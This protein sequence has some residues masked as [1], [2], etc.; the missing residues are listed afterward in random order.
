MRARL[1]FAWLLL[2][3]LSCTREV[4]SL[5]EEAIRFAVT[6][7]STEVTKTSYD[8]SNDPL[9]QRIDW[10]EGDRVRIMSDKAKA[11]IPPIEWA[12][13]KVG[14]ITTSGKRSIAEAVKVQDPLNWKSGAHKFYSL[15]PS[16]TTEGMD[17]KITIV[18]T[19]DDDFTMTCTIPQ[20]Q[21]L[22][23]TV[24]GDL[25]RSDPDMRHAYLWAFTSAASPSHDIIQLEYEPRFTAFEFVVTSS[26]I[27]SIHLTSFTLSTT[28]DSPLVGKFTIDIDGTTGNYVTTESSVSFTL[29]KILEKDKFL[30]ITVL[31][32]PKT[33]ENLKISFT[34]DEI[35]TRTLTI[36]RTD[37]T[38][39]SFA[40][41]KKHRFVNLDF[42]AVYAVGE[43]ITWKGQ[44][45]TLGV[46]ETLTWR[47]L[48]DI[49]ASG[50][51]MNESGDDNIGAGGEDMGAQTGE[52]PEADGQDMLPDDSGQTLTAIFADTPA[53]DFT[54]H[55]S[56]KLA[57]H[58]TIP[59]AAFSTYFVS[60]LTA[61]EGSVT[62][63]FQVS[64]SGERDGYAL[65]PACIALDDA[66]GVGNTLLVN[67][68][69]DYSIDEDVFPIP[70]LA[71][72]DGDL[73]FKALSGALRLTL[74][75]IPKGTK[76]LTVTTDKPL[77]GEYNVDLS[78]PV[79]ADMVPGTEK[80]MRWTYAVEAP[81]IIDGQV[82]NVPVPAGDYSF[83]K[84]SAYSV[85]NTVLG[86][87]G[88]YYS[89]HVTVGRA[90][91]VPL[92]LTMTGTGALANFKLSQ[93][94]SLITGQA[95]SSLSFT[96][97]QVRTGGGT[98]SASGYSLAVVGNTDPV[99]LDVS[100]SGTTITLTPLAPGSSH[101]TL[102]ATKGGVTLIASTDVTVNNFSGLRFRESYPYIPKNNIHAETIYPV[103][104]GVEVSAAALSFEWT[105]VEGGSL[106]TFDGATSQQFVRIKAGT[107]T[108]DVV[109]KCTVSCN[110]RE[111]ASE[112]RKV[113]IIQVPS[114]C[115]NG[116][117]S[118]GG[119]EAVMFATGNLTYQVSTNQYTFQEHQ[120]SAYSGSTEHPEKPTESDIFDVFK[121]DMVDPL[122]N[123]SYSPAIKVGGQN[124]RGWHLPTMTQIDFVFTGRSGAILPRI[125][126]DTGRYMLANVNGKKGIIIFPDCFVWP[127][128][129]VS[130]PTKLEGGNEY[131]VF[132]SI[133]LSDWDT[134]LEPMGCV[135]LPGG[136]DAPA[137]DEAGQENDY[138]NQKYYPRYIC[139]FDGSHSYFHVDL[140]DMDPTLHTYSVP[141]ALN[142]LY[143]GLADPY[144]TKRWFHV[145][146]AKRFDD[147]YA[148]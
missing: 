78:G 101:I 110:G 84:V 63:T 12:D 126:G 18:Q 98:Q 103:V 46:G 108:G 59:A 23:W 43:G 42:P 67:L 85:K 53:V 32:L 40:P 35:D 121:M 16:P 1:I 33:I 105:V 106:V 120:W 138:T 125:G 41:N 137:Y 50:E 77:S 82:L 81:A 15:Y 21:E 94:V 48:Q 132:D 134:Y 52:N 117:F 80:E 145:R 102:S 37:G 133:S 87:A 75:G 112:T 97:Q 142:N 7:A 6:G 17:G 131:C 39:L 96:I 22:G 140:Y 71:V 26:L 139:Y 14:T 56:D 9:S 27:P 76:Y 25:T 11:G 127:E 99:S 8:G 61:G 38:P 118:I 65:Y 114:G 79:L 3:L 116:V 73:S 113:S 47:A 86:T 100:V 36:R 69:Q 135:F 124:T 64:K 4:P 136:G 141:R 2:I 128:G 68:P 13:Y 147:P 146:L 24:D 90:Q 57:V 88:E 31:A 72:N 60:A 89:T 62:G 95:G 129:D 10:I 143:I 5:S 44:L 34:G 20:A 115:V 45:E 74:D 130:L 66:S 122:I 92:S 83:L 93:N 104:N 111:C 123:R 148:R 70:M 144:K 51:N 49:L 54:W 29:D 58:Y 119:G 19:V 91:V 28:D 107:T 30:S 109:L 55:G